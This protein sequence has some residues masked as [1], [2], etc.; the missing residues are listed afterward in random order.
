MLVLADRKS[1]PL[2]LELDRVQRRV[3]KDKLSQAAQQ[4]PAAL[5]AP[6]RAFGRWSLY[7]DRQRRR[8]EVKQVTPQIPLLLSHADALPAQCSAAVKAC[9]LL[10]HLKCLGQ[11]RNSGGIC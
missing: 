10:P 5:A 4:V 1:A 7:M 8:P 6:F 2:S 3:Q 11:R 9:Q